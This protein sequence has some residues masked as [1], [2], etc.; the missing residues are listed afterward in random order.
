[1]LDL[2]SPKLFAQI[3]KQSSWLINEGSPQNAAN[4]A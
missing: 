1:M 3:E 2:Q 4:M